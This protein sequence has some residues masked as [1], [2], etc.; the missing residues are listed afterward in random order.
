VGS[1]GAGPQAPEP[2]PVPAEAPRRL[3]QGGAGRPERLLAC[4]VCGLI[5]RWPGLPA[6]PACGSAPG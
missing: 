5:Q 6:C 2:E 1:P 3:D 4:E